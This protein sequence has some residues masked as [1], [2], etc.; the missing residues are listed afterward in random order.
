MA[1]KTAIG[2]EE[3]NGRLRLRLPR[4]VA[5][6]SSRYISTGLAPEDFRKA[7][8]V[9]WQ[10]EDDIKT[11]NLDTSLERYKSAFQQK[12]KVSKLSPE[13]LAGL[14][15]KY[16]DYMR[17]QLAETTYEKDYKRKYKNHIDRLPTKDINHATEIR[18]WLLTQH[19]AGTT[20]R[21]L[22]YLSA[23]CNWAKSSG[24]I[25][26][27]P[28]LGAAGDIKRPKVDNQIDPFSVSERQAI[29]EAFR[30]THYYSFVSF[31]FATGCRPGEAIAL[32]WED[33]NSDL[34]YIIFSKSYDSQLNILKSTKTG[35]TRRFPV[36][37]P[38]RLLI[39]TIR[40]NRPKPDLLV[41]PSPVGLHIHNG[42]FTN[43]VWRGCTVGGKTYRGIV[44][45]LVRQGLVE[46][47]RPPYNTR[48]TFITLALANGL[49]V[50]Q[51]A[52]LVGN[53]PEV[54]LRHYAG[55]SVKEVPEF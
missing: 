30:A 21:V 44:T 14:W 22:T 46:R 4:S 28:F 25:E 2:I 41:F 10:I 38:L 27:N 15:S 12:Q 51:V 18:D 16:S 31:L 8:A 6:G 40:P 33:I 53:S 32:T 5:D 39:E 49:T 26:T 3:K 34:D 36:N 43:Q 19:S 52:A 9:A 48:H 20:K 42:K 54:I 17:P 50:S 11:G 24:L 1:T 29:L 7:Q 55:A 45:K 23:C 37:R 13:D 35:E 47:Y